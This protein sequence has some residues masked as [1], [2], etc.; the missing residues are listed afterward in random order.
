MVSRTWFLKKAQTKTENIF[1]QLSHPVLGSS[2]GPAARQGK[3]SQRPWWLSAPGPRVWGQEAH[4]GHGIIHLWPWTKPKTNQIQAPSGSHRQDYR[5]FCPRLCCEPGS[6]ATVLTQPNRGGAGLSQ[7]EQGDFPPINHRSGPSFSVT[8]KEISLAS[9]YPSLQ[10]L[11]TPPWKAA[12]FLPMAMV[13]G[14][15]LM[16]ERGRGP[17]SNGL[18]RAQLLA[19]SQT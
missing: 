13:Q 2:K 5:E 8:S 11:P 19:C 6:D 12:G 3:A 18:S 15:L 7:V 14:W 17:S 4:L 1:R 10:L 9:C 16:Q